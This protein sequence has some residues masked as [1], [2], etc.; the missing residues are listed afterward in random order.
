MNSVLSLQKRVLSGKRV[1]SAEGRE[2]SWQFAVGSGQ[3]REVLSDG[4]E[5]AEC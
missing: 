4:K 3:G 2:D 5:S 1:L